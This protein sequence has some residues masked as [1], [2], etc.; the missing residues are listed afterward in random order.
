MRSFK[1][2][3]LSTTVIPAFVG[4][5]IVVGGALS[6]ATPAHAANTGTEQPTLL[7]VAKPKPR[8]IQ[9][10]QCKPCNP[11]AAKKG[12]NPCNPCAAK[13]GCNSCNPCAAKKGCNPC[14][15]C[16]AKR[17]CNP[18]NPC[19]AKGCNPCNPCGAGGGAFSKKC[20]I[21]R[22][23]TAKACNPCN[24]CAAKK[25]CNPC[26]P[27]AAK[28]GCNPCN[29][30]AAKKA[31]NP[32]NPCA[33]KGCNPC[34]PCGA[35]P[36]VEISAAEAEAAYICLKPEM[37]K[38][39][40][41]AGLRQVRGYAGW[42][43]VNATAYQSATHGGRYVNNYANSLGDYRYKKFEKAGTLPF[44]SVLA[45]DSF[46][47]R[48]DGKLGIGP[49]FIMEKMKKGFNKGSGD[50][51]YSMVMPN[52][53]VAGMTKGKGMN[54]KFCAVCHAGVAP[55]QDHILLVP[56]DYRKKF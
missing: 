45:K 2:S 5:G 15:P 44:G 13:K 29:P 23:H 52:G 11:C 21:P 41:K 32:C 19:A 40:R 8:S 55:E 53:K 48:P 7:P 51:R 25:G 6:P 34:N 49:L 16:A 22:L 50:W 39:Y 9:L 10:A 18:C 37:K 33:A 56:E 47:V 14:N 3:L 1:I 30:C 26:N 54:M 4:A 20:V 27:C 42:L 31:C 38:A 35:G 46:A 36:A 28:K 12:C 24:P 43:R 17:A